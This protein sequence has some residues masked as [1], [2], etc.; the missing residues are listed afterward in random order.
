M[1]TF[2]AVPALLVYH[3]ICKKKEP[4]LVCFESHPATQVVGSILRETSPPNPAKMAGV[5]G[6]GVWWLC[7]Q[8]LLK[9]WQ[10]HSSVVKS[11][12]QP[13]GEWPLNRG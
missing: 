10:T 6:A 1:L 7:E 3:S 9:S 11:H 13:F 5:N 8:T 12:F 2:Y 4:C